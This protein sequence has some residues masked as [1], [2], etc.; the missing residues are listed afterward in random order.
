MARTLKFLCS[1]PPDQVKIVTEFLEKD[2]LAYRTQSEMTP[3]GHQT[4]PTGL[5]QIFAES[6]D[7]M[8]QMR[9]V[10]EVLPRILK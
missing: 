8:Q 10:S 7:A 9:Y 6:M 5:V 4:V 1:L 3:L 2:Q